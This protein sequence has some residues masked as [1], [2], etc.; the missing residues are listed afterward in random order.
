MPSSGVD[1]VP[2]DRGRHQGAVGRRERPLLADVRR[3]VEAGRLLAEPLGALARGQVEVRP[4]RRHAG[5]TRPRRR[6][7]PR[8]ARRCARPAPTSDA[9]SETGPTTMPSPVRS[10][11]R[12]DPQLVA[13]AGP[14]REHHV[15][16]VRVDRSSRSAGSSGRTGRQADGSWS[17]ERGTGHRASRNSVA[18]SLVTSSS[19]SEPSG[20]RTCSAWYSTPRRRPPTERGADVGLARRRRPRPRWCPG[21]PTRSPPGRR[22]GS[23]RTSSSNCSSGSSSTSSSVGGGRAEPVPPDLV[24]PPQLVVHGVEEVRRVRRPGPAGRRPRHDVGQVRARSRGRG[25]A[26]RRPRRRRSPPSRPAA[27]ASGE[28]LQSPRST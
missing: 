9:M 20:C 4:D 15:P 18:S 13:A 3:G 25:T 24:L 1:A 2:Q 12:Q 8:R 5:R 14:R 11:E 27:T 7:G 26:A 19:S 21:S 23:R 17:P 6:S 22:C 16:G 28:T 10:S